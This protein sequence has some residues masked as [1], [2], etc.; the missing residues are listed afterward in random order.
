MDLRGR[1]WTGQRSTLPR[2]A[3]VVYGVLRRQRTVSSKKTPKKRAENMANPPYISLNKAAKLSGRAKSTISTALKSGKL[4]YVSVDAKNGYEID[5]AEVE[6]VFPNSGETANSDRNA[7][8]EKTSERKQL[9]PSVH[10]DFQRELEIFQEE[11]ERERAQLNDRIAEL[12]NQLDQ[13]Q[14]ERRSAQTKLMA[15]LESQVPARESEK[16]RGFVLWPFGRKAGA[17]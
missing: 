2:L 15:L 9:P 1:L 12:K 14:D 17:A 11:R 4:S 5:P 13:A 16:G 6:R 8:L 7:N 10:P 3:A